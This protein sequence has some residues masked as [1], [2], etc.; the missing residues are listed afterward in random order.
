M[1][2]AAPTS[3]TKAE[4]AQS[5]TQ[6]VPQP[7]R[8]LHPHLFSPA[9]LYSPGGMSRAASGASPDG[10]RRQAFDGM[11]NTHG[12]QAVLR[13]LHSSQKVAR[14][15]PLRPSQGIM[16][17]RKCACG[18]S[19]EST[20][21][22][23]EC[24]AEREA[25]LQRRAVN[26]NAAPA[27]A[28]GVRSIV[29]DVL[30]SPGQPLDAGTRA[31][32]EPRFGHDFSQV[33]V[34]TDAKAAESARAVNALAYTVGRNMVFGA[35]QYAP[36]TSEG[37]WLMAHELTHVV[38]QG[39][40]STVDKYMMNSLVV[41]SPSDLFEQEAN[42]QASKV[43]EGYPKPISQLQEQA[44]IA[45]I[46][47]Q[48]SKIR[49]TSSPQPVP[50]SPSG[51]KGTVQAISG[52]PGRTL[53]DG[54]RPFR[55]EVTAVPVDCDALQWE[56]FVGGY[57]I[58]RDHQGNVIMQN[59]C[60]FIRAHINKK[61]KQYGELCDDIDED[62]EPGP[63]S[64]NTKKAYTGCLGKPPNVTY[65]SLDAPGYS[66]GF[67]VPIPQTNATLKDGQAMGKFS[68]IEYHLIFEHKLWF[69]D[70]EPFGVSF[71]LTG[72]LSRAGDKT[73]LELR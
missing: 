64:V 60:E 14:I 30:H 12:N 21:E 43:M 4:T 53:F 6:V 25:T 71:S 27:G 15:T 57:W 58:I 45:R 73:K 13:M 36:G 38:Q 5:K 10:Q 39:Q 23:A 29:H 44:E 31:F 26:A 9:G 52:I 17:Q 20:G 47:R 50:P 22:C 61:S 49:T 48:T 63:K 46:Q 24:K 7:E 8:E 37:R 62:M 41:G 33:R 18:D 28:Q 67:D 54:Q 19:S 66:V 1:L 55:I 56:Q 32:M 65:V 68:S 69:S 11:Q 51:M 2:H 42:L 3:E 40:A 59:A 72:K 16:F 35:G 34:H 70:R